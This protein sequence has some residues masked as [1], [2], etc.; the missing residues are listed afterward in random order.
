MFVDCEENSGHPRQ[1]YCKWGKGAILGH[2]DAQERGM[3][4]WD[5]QQRDS[6]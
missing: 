3:M 5:L 4:A 6:A 2:P 1:T